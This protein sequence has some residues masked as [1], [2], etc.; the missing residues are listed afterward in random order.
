MINS[1]NWAIL[2]LDAQPII[3]LDEVAIYDAVLNN[4]NTLI[5]LNEHS[6]YANW[7]HHNT[8]EMVEYGL[9]YTNRRPAIKFISLDTYTSNDADISVII[10]KYSTIGKAQIAS[11]VVKHTLNIVKP[12]VET[13]P[14]KLSIQ[15]QLNRLLY[16]KNNGALLNSLLDK[17][18]ISTPAYCWLK[19]YL[20]I[21]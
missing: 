17:Q 9:K 1:S 12:I 2:F 13:C 15:D 14:T 10:R 3:K 8:R 6:L 4:K 18:S 11:K 21:S 7:N 5:V 20:Q 16:S 19:Q